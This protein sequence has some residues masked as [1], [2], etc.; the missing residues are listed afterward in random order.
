MNFIGMIMYL[1]VHSFSNSSINKTILFDIGN[2]YQL[3]LH[4]NKINIAI[5]D[6][7][8]NTTIMESFLDYDFF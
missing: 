8:Q 7:P 2:K 3:E 1:L 4:V 5:K 6:T